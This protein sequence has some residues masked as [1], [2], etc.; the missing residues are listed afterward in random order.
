MQ[1]FLLLDG[2]DYTLA[3]VTTVVAKSFSFSKED[4]S[5]LSGRDFNTAVI[6]AS[7]TA[8]GHSDA[9]QLLDSLPYFVSDTFVKLRDAA[10]EV[11]GFKPVKMGEETPEAAPASTGS[12]ST[13]A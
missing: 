6:A 13:D 7:L 12:A 8:G 2:T 1:K 9:A 11:N 5:A 3:T 4:G 10:Y